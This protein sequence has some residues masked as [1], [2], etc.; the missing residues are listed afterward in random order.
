M[1]LSTI[2]KNL[3]IRSVQTMAT[4]DL[5]SESAVL[6]EEMAEG[7]EVVEIINAELAGRVEP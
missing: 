3:L 7:Q 2:A 4:E 5:Q 1:A 6:A